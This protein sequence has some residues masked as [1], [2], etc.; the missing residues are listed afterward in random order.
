MSASNHDTTT[1][2]TATKWAL[3]LI[4]CPKIPRIRNAARGSSGITAYVIRLRSSSSVGYDAFL[5]RN[6]S[7]QS[8]R[9]SRA[10]LH[11]S[12]TTALSPFQQL[13]FVDVDGGSGSIQGDDDGQSDRNLCRSNGEGKEDKDLP[14]H[15][16]EVLRKCDKINICRIQHQFD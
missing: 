7:K 9:H 3:S 15:I 13:K 5:K 14:C 16:V 12:R 11:V 2:G 6:T 10:T 4:Q 1:A 8:V